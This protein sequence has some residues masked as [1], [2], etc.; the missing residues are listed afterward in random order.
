MKKHL[1]ITWLTATAL[2]VANMIGTGVFTSLGFQVIEIQSTWSI[3]TLWIL[4]GIIALSGAFSYAELGSYYKESGGE[5]LFLSRLYHPIIGYLAGWVSLTVGFAAPVA[6]AA[7]ALGKYVTPYLNI[8]SEYLAVG[9]V[10]LVSFAHSFNLNRSSEFQNISTALKVILILFIIVVGLV[11]SPVESGINFNPEWMGEIWTP[12][13]A[14]AIV[15]VTYSYTGWNA[16]AYIAEEI[17]SVKSN[18][19]K[20]LIRG[21]LIVTFL[22]VLLQFVFLRH[23]P[24]ENLMGKVEVGHVF[25]DNIFQDTGGK[26]ISL[27]ISL[28]LLSSISAMIWVGPRV[29]SKMAND[30]SLWRFLRKPDR[31]QIPIRAVWFQGLLSAIMIISGTFESVL[32]YCGFILQLSSALTVLGTFKLRKITRDLP[33]K[34]PTYPWFPLFFIIISIWILVFLIKDKPVESAWGMINIVLGILSYY[35]SKRISRTKIA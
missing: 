24:I 16:A 34:N 4:G 33:Y 2:V 9:T 32:L 17:Q 11:V 31:S 6:L 3:L 1:K 27:L 21:T 5:Y 19:P 8:S 35:F 20:A 30:Y 26:I 25:A 12:A 29:S 18:L 7:I 10:L 13:F 14:V 15:F 22:Y 23:V 28:F